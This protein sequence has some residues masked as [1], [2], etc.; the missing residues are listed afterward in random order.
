MYWG[1]VQEDLIAREYARQTGQKVRRPGKMYRHPQ[2]EWMIAHP[3]RLVLNTNRGL[4]CKTS[5]AYMAGEWGEPGTDEV[6]EQYLIQVQHYI[7]VCG[8]GGC[9]LALLLG[10][11]D[12]R[13]YPIERNDRLIASLVERERQFWENHVVAGI[14]PPVDGS[15]ACAEALR[16][17]YPQDS[18]QVIEATPELDELVHQYQAAKLNEKLVAEESLKYKNAIQ[19]AMGDASIL[20]GPD[21][22]ITWKTAKDSAKLDI[23]AFREAE[24]ELYL[25]VLGKYQTSAGGGRR[26]LGPTFKKERS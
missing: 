17:L 7:A 20:V 16:L 2:F 24:P 10:G 18:G 26:F 15:K 8:W 12:F 11:N 5:G 19:A 22:K 6:P 13:I 4:E 25:Q 3:D 23:P 9:D 21:W 14:L 1:V